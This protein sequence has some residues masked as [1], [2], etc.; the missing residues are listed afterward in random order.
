MILS[1]YIQFLKDLKLGEYIINS[2]DYYSG[3]DNCGYMVQTS[4][5][6]YKDNDPLQTEQLFTDY[7]GIAYNGKAYF[8]Y[9]L[10]ELRACLKGIV[11]SR[12][13]NRR[14]I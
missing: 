14:S 11:L 12:T 1:D 4:E 5:T 13:I 9:D 6:W 2:Q 7:G 8:C 10:D 3:L